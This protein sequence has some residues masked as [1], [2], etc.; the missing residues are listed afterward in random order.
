[1]RLPARYLESSWTGISVVSQFWK[2]ES[3]A[4]SLHG[5]GDV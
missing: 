3:L 2:G 1:M 4:I 5:H